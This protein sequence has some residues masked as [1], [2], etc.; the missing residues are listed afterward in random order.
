MRLGWMAVCLLLPA[1][2][3]VPKPPDRPQPQVSAPV[4]RAPYGNPTL[5]PYGNPTLAPYGPVQEMPSVAVRRP[6]NAPRQ[7]PTV[8]EPANDPDTA[9]PAQDPEVMTTPMPA[10]TTGASKKPA[11]TEAPRA[12]PPT[13]L[14][15]PPILQAMHSYM[16]KRPDQAVDMLQRYPAENQDALLILLPLTVRMTESSF[17]DASPQEMA[18]MVDQLQ[19]LQEMF[20]PRA[21]LVIDKLCFCRQ[22]HGYGKYETLG[23]TP[24]FHVQEMVE[25]YAEIRNL[26]CEKAPVRPV[27]GYRTH[28][29]SR[30]EIRDTAGSYVW[31]PPV[32]EKRD[33]SQTP[34]H[35]YFHHYRFAL[36]DMPPGDYVLTVEVTDVPTGRRV[37]GKLE[38]RVRSE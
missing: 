23:E 12:L 18:A 29:T 14:D 30:L 31:K 10:Q 19:Q 35:D 1:C 26:T 21:A 3:P 16:D 8:A 7:R 2:F 36:P 4:Y 28:L 37:K 38:F 11:L 20:Q 24:V 6:N 33:I 34:Q 25:L 9:D 13:V 22:V 32:R 5:A 15:E 27:C 17:R